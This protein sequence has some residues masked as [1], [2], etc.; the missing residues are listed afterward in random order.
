MGA[1]ERRWKSGRRGRGGGYRDTKES[2]DGAG[3]DDSR[4]DG[5]ETGKQLSATLKDILAAARERRWKSGRLGGGG[6]DRYVEESEDGAG[7]NWSRDAGTE[8]GDTQ[9]GE[10]SCVAARRK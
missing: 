1:R 5:M 10:R 4:D 6:L 8:T 3:S 2:K 7:R 9:V